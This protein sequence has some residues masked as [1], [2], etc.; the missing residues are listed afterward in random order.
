M[1]I[2]V[3]CIVAAVAGIVWGGGVRVIVI[4]P[5]GVLPDGV[6]AIVAGISGAR[7]LDSPDAICARHEGGVSVLCRAREGAAIAE[8]GIILARLPYSE[9]L[10]RL[11]GAPTAG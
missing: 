1:K 9:T 11:T 6:T 7:L 3:L 10:F 4:Q 2:A 8:N 5:L